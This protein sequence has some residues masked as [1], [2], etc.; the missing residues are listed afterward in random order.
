MA[1]KRLAFTSSGDLSAFAGQLGAQISAADYEG[2]LQNQVTQALREAGVTCDDA[3]FD[4]IVAAIEDRR[5]GFGPL[6][7]L[8]SD[9]DITDI[10]V[11]RYDEV[12]VLRSAGWIRSRL[13]FSNE[14]ELLDAIRRVVGLT[15][16]DINVTA[17]IVDARMPTVK[18]AGQKMRGYADEDEVPGP[19]ICATIPPASWQS[20]TLSI[21]KYRPL[22]LSLRDLYSRPDDTSFEPTLDWEMAVFLDTCVRARL[23]LIVSGGTGSGKTTFLAALMGR[24][25]QTERVILIED[26]PELSFAAGD[27]RSATWN[28]PR[29]IT[30]RADDTR[31]P[32]VLLRTALRMSP[33]RII[34]GECRGGEALT[35]ISAMNTGHEGSMSTVH[36]NSA[37][38]ALMRIATLAMLNPLPL[39]LAT[40]ESQVASAIHLVI[41]LVRDSRNGVRSIDEIAEVVHDHGGIAMTKPIW[42][43][44]PG[45]RGWIIN[46][47]P[48]IWQR[49]SRHWPAEA[50]DPFI[51]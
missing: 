41:H 14:N 11:N 25:P 2:K 16:H 8:I 35:M 13:S 20:P 29:L 45:G 3:T 48:A 42:Q 22:R 31:S 32:D 51:A 17:P 6:A 18:K 38:D 36:A 19:R 39:P 1:N 27:N 44:D 21:R 43:R 7:D 28:A 33:D 15:E 49:I 40:I 4:A 34:V 5:G 46:A 30:D 47:R 37:A 9:P 10:V 50:P 12:W 26:T 24:I 23:N